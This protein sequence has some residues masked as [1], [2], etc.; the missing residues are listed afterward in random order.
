[1]GKST[2]LEPEEHDFVFLT[3]LGLRRFVWAF[4][5]CDEQVLLVAVA[6]L[7]GEHGL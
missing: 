7:V 6:S 1:M 4:P 3:V 2:I 5:S